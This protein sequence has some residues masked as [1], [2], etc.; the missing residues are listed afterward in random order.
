MDTRFN[1]LIV[2]ARHH[3]IALRSTR[4]SPEVAAALALTRSRATPG[5]RR[6]R[7][8]FLGPA[9]ARGANR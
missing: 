5:R 6:E 3:E 8:R 1:I 2:E 4:P 9:P 7:R